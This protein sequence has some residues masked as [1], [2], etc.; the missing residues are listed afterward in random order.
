[1]I[2]RVQM[3]DQRGDHHE[4]GGRNLSRAPSVLLELPQKEERL[5][6][7]WAVDELCVALGVQRKR[8]GI[9]H[10]KGHRGGAGAAHATRTP[11]D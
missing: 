4:L 1:M 2:Y 11:K 5:P 6:V 7:L 10:E 3:V 9:E 8:Q